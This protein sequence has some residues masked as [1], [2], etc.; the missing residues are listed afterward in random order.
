M[1]VPLSWV[2]FEAE[3]GLMKYTREKNAKGVGKVDGEGKWIL[4]DPDAFEEGLCEEKGCV[5]VDRK[6]KE[7]WKI[8]RLEKSGGGVV[9]PKELRELLDVAGRRWEEWMDVLGKVEKEKGL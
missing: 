1:P 8:V 4:V 2:V 5:V 3:S 7:G 9:G 6:G